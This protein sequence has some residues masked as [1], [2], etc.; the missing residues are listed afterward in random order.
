VSK[1]DFVDWLEQGPDAIGFEKTAEALAFRDENPQEAA[2]LKARHQAEQRERDEVESIVELAAMKGM[3]DEE[4]AIATAKEMI[5]DRR[6]QAL[7]EL[8]EKSRADF[9]RAAWR[10][11]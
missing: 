6:A 11:F 4:A 3:A 2:R 1:Q 8:D 10:A 5:K 7:R 9:E